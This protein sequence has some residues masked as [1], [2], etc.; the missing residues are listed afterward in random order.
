MTPTT[1]ELS[2]LTERIGKLEKQNRRIRRV[3]AVAL[4]LQHRFC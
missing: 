2:S 1:P 4:F 3:G